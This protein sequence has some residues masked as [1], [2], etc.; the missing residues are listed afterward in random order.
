MKE[1]KIET[2]LV[3]IND[4]YGETCID[5]SMNKI[6]TSE[7]RPKGFVKVYEVIDGIKK[8]RERQN[9]VLYQGREYLAERL[10]NIKNSNV[11]ADPD[12]F[13]CW[14]GAGDGG[15]DPGD[16]F[17]P[18]VPLSVDTDLASEVAIN[19]TD[20]TCADY[21]DGAYYKRPYD[22]VEFSRD[23]VNDNRWLILEI[24]TTLNT[25]DCNGEQLSEAGLF[26][27]ASD[28]GG[29]GGPFNIFARVTF[30]SIVKDA[31]RQLIFV[32]YIYL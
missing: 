6:N 15:V 30:S 5:D 21:H 13:L 25:E 18:I 19:A 10:V 14:F 31:T 11:T 22:T 2:I 17:V 8:L 4:S 16:P 12:E 20:S 27:A 1:N 23:V 28:A 26:T 9:L 24:T 32:W 7:R 3:K 29:Y